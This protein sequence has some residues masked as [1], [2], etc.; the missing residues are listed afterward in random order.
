M[1][2]LTETPC[3]ITVEPFGVAKRWRAVEPEAYVGFQ[4]DDDLREALQALRPLALAVVRL[5]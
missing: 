5:C 2:N 1:T 4:R 3:Y